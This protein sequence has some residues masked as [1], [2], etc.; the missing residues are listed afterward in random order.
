MS[1]QIPLTQGHV[2]IVDNEDYEELMQYR[3]HIDAH[4]QGPRVMRTTPVDIHGKQGGVLMHRQIMDAPLGMDVDHHNHDQ[5]DNRRA[6]LRVCT[7][8]QNM[9]NMRKRP[10]C[11]SRFK[12]VYLE[13]RTGRWVA[14]I[15]VNLQMIALGT[16][17]QETR[18]ARAYNVA[19][20]EHFGEFALLNKI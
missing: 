9:A 13:K 20:I 5:L 6:N 14:R 15:R 3:W 4:P 7:R 2:A 1:K 8:S 19:A 10:G 18:A 17:E 12:G 11:S 16:F